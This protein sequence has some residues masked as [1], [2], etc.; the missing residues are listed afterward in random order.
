MNRYP[1]LRLL[2]KYGERIAVGAAIIMLILTLWAAW[3]S[4]SPLMAVVGMLV[5]AGVY[6]AVRSFSELV[7]LVTDMLLPKEFE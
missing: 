7:T 1:A 5:A 2:T 3:A 4:W 6:G